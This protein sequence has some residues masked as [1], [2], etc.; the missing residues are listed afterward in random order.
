MIVSTGY[1]A[2]TQPQQPE[3]PNFQ[4]NRTQQL[5]PLANLIIIQCRCIEIR[6]IELYIKS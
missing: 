3:I 5:L 2:E 4:S 1:S 6:N